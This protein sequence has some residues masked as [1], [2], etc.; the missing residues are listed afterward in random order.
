MLPHGV[1]RTRRRRCVKR[2]ANV[3]NRRDA[4][5]Y[6]SRATYIHLLQFCYG[7]QPFLLLGLTRLNHQNTDRVF[8]IVF[9]LGDSVCGP[10]ATLIDM[11][12]FVVGLLARTAACQFP[13]KHR[14]GQNL[15]TFL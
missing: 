14:P 8:D 4:S 11:V 13:P 9:S 6:T 2:P 10:V 5:Y 1:I 12:C 7:L 3:T 15:D